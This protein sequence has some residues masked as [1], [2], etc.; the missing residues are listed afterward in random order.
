MGGGPR[1]DV[2]RGPRREVGAM[3]A[4][5]TLKGHMEGEDGPEGSPWRTLCVTYAL[6]D[7]QAVTRTVRTRHNPRTYPYRALVSTGSVLCD[8][9][10]VNLAHV[11]TVRWTWDDGSSSAVPQGARELLTALRDAL[12]E[13]ADVTERAKRL[14]AYCEDEGIVPPR[15]AGP[16]K[17]E[18]D[19]R[20]V[21]HRPI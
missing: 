21:R 18:G 7:G 17:A 13:D 15:D 20:D 2:G 1:E 5:P 4:T 12:A 14:V 8:D 16:A 19:R 9:A 6:D 3:R 11:T 10:V